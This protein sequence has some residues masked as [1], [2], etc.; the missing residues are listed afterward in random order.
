[1]PAIP[2]LSLVIGIMIQSDN[3]S[4]DLILPCYNPHEGWQELVVCQYKVLE[5]VWPQIQ[6]HLCIVDDGSQYGFEKPV[7]DFLVTN[8]VHI[9]I[10]R[11]SKNHGKGYA[12]R[13]GIAVCSGDMQVYTDYDIPYTLTSMSKVISCLLRG[14][15]I[16]VPS[17][18]K[19]YDRQLPIFRRCISR[20]VRWCNH[21]LFR[22]PYSDTQ[23]G[24]K[25]LGRKG[26]TVFLNTHIDTYLCDWEFVLK[27]SRISTL[28]IVTT[29]IELRKDVQLP[30]FTWSICWNE[31]VNCL[32]MLRYVVLNFLGSVCTVCSN[33]RTK[34]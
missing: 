14:A 30:N 9:K 1:M 28:R 23:A 11:L 10:I 5:R 7:V 26:R 22:L 33:V 24:L 27:A 16:V 3:R 8:I 21:Y 15:D 13:E 20:L 34:G 2:C 31:F 18:S 12:L 4:I 29:D 6:F 25:G 32:L 17:R 19:M